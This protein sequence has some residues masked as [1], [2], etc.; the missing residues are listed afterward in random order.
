M[1]DR[2][3]AI[4]CICDDFFKSRGDEHWHNIK[5]TD[6]ELA[7]AF[8]L[9]EMT[10]QHTASLRTLIRERPSMQATARRRYSRSEEGIPSGTYARLV[11]EESRYVLRRGLYKILTWY[12]FVRIL[13]RL[14]E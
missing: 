2:I 14:C 13:M 9:T 8:I 10:F 12:L 4:Y 7:T 3:I 1:I 6:A 11:S 5:T